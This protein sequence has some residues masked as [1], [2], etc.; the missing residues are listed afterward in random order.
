MVV[1][2]I[3]EDYNHT[4]YGKEERIGK[5]MLRDFRREIERKRAE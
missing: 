5:R 2:R 4:V 1:D 3:G